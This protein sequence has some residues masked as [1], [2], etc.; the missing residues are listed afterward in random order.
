MQ[1]CSMEQPHNPVHG[2]A[3]PILTH[4]RVKKPMGNHILPLLYPLN[5]LAYCFSCST[6]QNYTQS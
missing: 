4:P 1:D 3:A 5:Y 2:E 6:V